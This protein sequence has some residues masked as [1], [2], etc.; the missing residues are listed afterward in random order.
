MALTA[1]TVLAQRKVR[2][3]IDQTVD[4]ATRDLVQAW[5][6]AW[7]EIADEW[8]AAI[9]ELLAA[10]D[11]SWP[12]RG[13]IRRVKRAGRALEM[14][15]AKL[16]ELSKLAGVR[17]L[18]DVPSLM[19][20]AEEWERKLAVSQLD[21]GLAVDW[22]RI[23]PKAADG[24]VKRTTGQVEAVTKLLPFDQ[25]AVMKQLLIRGVI[26]GDNP[27]TVAAQMLRR[28]GGAFDGG[29]WRAENIART[30]ML[31]AYRRS[32]L[33]SRQ[34]NADVLKG[35]MWSSD[36]SARTCPACLGMD[37]QTFPTGTPGPNGHQ[38]C[39]CTAIPVTRTWAELGIDAPE[40][41]SVYQ[42]GRDWFDQQPKDVQVEILGPARYRE[43][44]AGRLTWDQM[45][46]TRQTDGWRDSV[47]VAPL[48]PAA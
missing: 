15:A 17:I 23:D 37:G 42:T 5:G 48:R 19:G 4:A 8:S 44:A 12:S 9:T 13:A 1:A 40:P 27:K 45:I 11:G 31:D 39:R 7:D 16:D 35:W 28:L 33:E 14:T 24:I 41:V 10:G 47:A 30:E 46:R 43:W 20:L 6:R 29:R 32:A 36:K 26:V 34:A 2:I 38:S 25:Q 21:P 3:Q 18:R 22:N